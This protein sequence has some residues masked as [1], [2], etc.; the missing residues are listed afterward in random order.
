M[1]RDAHCPYLNKLDERCGG[2]FSLQHPEL[3]FDY[4]FGQPSRCPTY[5]ELRAEQR[6]AG[7][8]STHD[9]EE[10]HHGEAYV[11]LTVAGRH[12]E[13]VAAAA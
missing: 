10:P 4:C 1:R 12:A 13:R 3:A 9:L 11:Q 7:T 2:N 8:P 6:A 5:R